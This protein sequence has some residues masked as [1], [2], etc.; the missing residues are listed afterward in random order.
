MGTHVEDTE[1][2]VPGQV[3]CEGTDHSPGTGT[4]L[5]GN[6]VY[7]K[8][9]GTVGFRGKNEVRVTPHHVS[10]NPSAG[11]M[12]IGEV[13]RVSSSNYNIDIGCPYSGFLHINEAVD[14]YVDHDEDISK[15][16]DVGDLLI[17]KIT[18][19]TKGKDID[20]TMEAENARKLEGGRVIQVPPSKV[21][22]IIGTGGSMVKMLK[23][24]TDTQIIIGQNGRVWIDGGDMDLAAEAVR[25][26]AD[27]AHEDNLQDRIERWLDERQGDS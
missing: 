7:A 24:K 4:Y 3:L 14:E 5:E 20:M 26:V 23:Q 19:V 12:V 13:E 8:Y 15:Y 27:H 18:G 9:V 6:T 17:G 1:I 2:V 22:H 10:Y 21:S 11:D 16:F 25:R